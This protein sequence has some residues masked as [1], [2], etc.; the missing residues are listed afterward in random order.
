MKW[1]CLLRSPVIR[2]AKLWLLG[3][4][5]R[6]S[7]LKEGKLL[8]LR[9]FSSSGFRWNLRHHRSI[10]YYWLRVTFHSGVTFDNEGQQCTIYSRIY[11]IKIILIKHS[12][13]STQF[14]TI[15]TL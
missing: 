10:M 5:E 1:S 3:D 7:K 11:K 2:S 4:Y 6:V 12:K 15:R 14:T 8:G 9:L 13:S